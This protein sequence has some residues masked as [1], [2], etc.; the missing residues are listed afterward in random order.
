MWCNCCGQSL[1]Q[2]SPELPAAEL[3]A[4]TDEQFVFDLDAFIARPEEKIAV[5][6]LSVGRVVLAN[7]ARKGSRR[8][9]PIISGLYPKATAESSVVRGQTAQPGCSLNISHSETIKKSREG[10]LL[11]MATSFP[12]GSA[13]Y[14]VCCRNT[15]SASHAMTAVRC[16]RCR[17]TA[18]AHALRVATEITGGP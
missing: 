10:E 5:A 13:P 8:R 18:C 17:F 16:H 14:E 6:V 9:R 7:A 1:E 12:P 11:P 4:R 2:Y 15:K 3:T